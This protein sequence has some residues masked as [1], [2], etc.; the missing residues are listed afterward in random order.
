MRFDFQCMVVTR[1]RDSMVQH[2]CFMPTSPSEM[3]KDILLKAAIHRLTDRLR[4]RIV[5]SMENGIT[6]PIARWTVA[7]SLTL[8]PW[9]QRLF[10]RD[11][12]VDLKTPLLF[13][14]VLDQRVLYA[15]LIDGLCMQMRAHERPADA[16]QRA[17]THWC[18]ERLDDDPK[19]DFPSLS[20]YIDAWLEPIELEVDGRAA[21]PR[22]SLKKQ[23]ASLLGAKPSS[24]MDELRRVGRCLDDSVD[25]L[26]QLYG[27]DD[28]VVQL[29]EH[30][31]SPRRHGVLLLGSPSVGKTA[32]LREVVLRRVRDRQARSRNTTKRGQVWQ[33]SPARVVSGM[34]YLGQWEQRWLSILKGAAHH[35]HV[36]Y[37]DDPIALY[38]AGIT[39]DSNL[40]MADVLRSFIATTPLRFVF[41]MT[42][43]ELAIMR[44]RD[45]TLTDGCATLSIEP[46][47]IEETQTVLVDCIAQIE[48]TQRCSFHP[49]LLPSMIQYAHAVSPHQALPGKAIE[50]AR[51]LVAS[52]RQHSAS[53]P[54]QWTPVGISGDRLVAC[55]EQRHGIRFSFRF[56]GQR[57]LA[58]IERRLRSQVV[59]QPKAVQTLARYVLR[60]ACGLQPG[61]RPLG[62]FLLMGPTGVGKT[63]SAKALTR[64]LF[65][66]DARLVRI[67][68]NEVTTAHAASQLIGTF[69][70]PDGRL[71]SAIRRQPHG[72]LLL[73]EIE[74]AHP[75][76]HDYLL[77]VLGEGRLTDARGRLV[78]FRNVFI[79]LTS[80]LGAT[81]VNDAVGFDEQ[82]GTDQQRYHRV[83]RGF[84]RPEF[85]NRLDEI[86]IFRHL[87]RPDMQGIAM[88]QIR[89][90]TQRHG[91]QRRRV[92][93]R[94]ESTAMNWIVDQG[95]HPRLGARAVHR[96]IEAYVAQPLSDQLARLQVSTPT[97]IRIA[98]DSAGNLAIQTHPLTEPSAKVEP[99]PLMLSQ[100]IERGQAIQTRQQHQLTEIAD[101]WRQSELNWRRAYYFAMREQLLRLRDQLVAAQELL[102]ATPRASITPVQ[103]LQS[104]PRPP[105]SVRSYSYLGHEWYARDAQRANDEIIDAIHANQSPIHEPHAASISVGALRDECAVT[106]SMLRAL[107]DHRRWLIG[108]RSL[109]SSDYISV[110]PQ[111]TS[112]TNHR[113]PDDLHQ[114][115]GPDQTYFLDQL[116]H[117]LSA[118]LQL[119]AQPIDSLP[120]VRLVQGLGASDWLW[121]I[122]GTYEME[123]D[124]S[125][126]VL[127]V[128]PIDD[129]HADQQGI[130]SAWSKTSIAA[131]GQPRDEHCGPMGWR[132]IRGTIGRK[133]LAM[134]KRPK[135]VGK[136]SATSILPWCLDHLPNPPEWEQ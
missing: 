23:L 79:L 80:N 7:Q 134:A 117:L 74:K 106:D 20:N 124:R 87:K 14:T 85:F 66:D 65:T 125:L 50:L 44:R 60:A 128:V 34:S 69:D 35:D 6:L 39:R 11:R 17:I 133:T 40:S 136:K 70:E 56:N 107:T 130:L 105:R 98:C 103:P 126:A 5:E 129:D 89:D 19:Y 76:V 118:D 78:D 113:E 32:I 26:G 94:V 25:A 75:D 72:V 49:G 115:T 10:L 58:D 36:L 61:D 2:E 123:S 97:W 41:E 30:L 135:P 108:F 1:R 48:A 119:N 109:Q 28:Q 99:Q 4:K 29:K 96:A 53:D 16:A 42:A 22:R 114:D 91:L 90:V 45:R 95:F 18:E 102:E 31:R 88:K 59:A 112:E 8:V 63:E 122:A 120:A 86:I 24:G 54:T 13:Q 73:D 38:A 71:T 111:E 46:M 68:M 84:F 93:L 57:R 100:A 3:S 21:R 47:T 67:D 132:T 116:T 62:A 77:Q 81:E 12:S 27:R 83:A 43:G 15:P 92:A 131:N 110:D 121:Q 9:K 101:A 55:L 33:V 52:S 82:T 127:M 104:P 37:F 64:L 51:D